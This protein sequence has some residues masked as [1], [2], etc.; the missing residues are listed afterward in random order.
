MGATIIWTLGIGASVALLVI[1][2]AMKLHYLHM[3]VAAAVGI[4]MAVSAFKDARQYATGQPG[5]ARV[6]SNNLRHMGMIWA[7]GAVTIFATYAF[8]IL[9]WR[10][11]MTFFVA[12]MV[13]SGLSLFLSATLRKD[14]EAGSKDETMLKVAR[15]YAT[16][17][18]AAMVITAIGLVVDGKLWRFTTVAGQRPN[19][20]DWAANNI[21]FFGA[22]AMAAV[23]WHTIQR[24]KATKS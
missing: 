12:L 3:V 19:S 11:W 20:Q 13:L 18:L 24:L 5:L 14:A 16:F 17:M 22:L 1:S 6:A 9:T 15:G 10:E 7:W 23:A 2:A 21:F 8:R 4:L